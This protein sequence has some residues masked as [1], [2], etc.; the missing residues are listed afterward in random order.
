MRVR[1]VA[2]RAR[3]RRRM[4][5]VAKGIKD[6]SA[7]E[8]LETS[9]AV[10]TAVVTRPEIREAPCGASRSS[11]LCRRSSSFRYRGSRSRRSSPSVPSS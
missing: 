8:A 1:W 7:R 3:V 5:A 4:A 10:V 2:G 11:V 9:Y 6:Q